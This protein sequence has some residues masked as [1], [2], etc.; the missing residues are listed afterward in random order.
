MIKR[1]YIKHD[2]SELKYQRLLPELC[3]I[4][5]LNYTTFLWHN[6]RNN[7]YCIC[8]NSCLILKSYVLSIKARCVIGFIII[9]LSSCLCYYF[10]STVKH[11]SVL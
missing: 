11:L 1:I 8:E 2:F 4:T 7:T 6:N 5:S 10:F 9:C 3:L